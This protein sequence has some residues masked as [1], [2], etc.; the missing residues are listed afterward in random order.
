MTPQQNDV[1]KRMNR[2]IE[3][4]AQGLRLNAKLANILGRCSEIGIGVGSS[5]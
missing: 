5:L 1:A 3:E 2:S 4:R